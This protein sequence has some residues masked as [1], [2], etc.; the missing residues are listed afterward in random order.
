ML[1]HLRLSR[2]TRLGCARL[3]WLACT[4]YSARVGQLTCSARVGWL[5][6]MLLHLL[7]P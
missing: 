7:D 3:G 6:K 1:L 2:S 5:D 4:A